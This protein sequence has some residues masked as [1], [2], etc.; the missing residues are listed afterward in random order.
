MLWASLLPQGDEWPGAL[1]DTDRAGT[2]GPCDLTAEEAIVTPFSQTSAGLFCI[3][4]L[5]SKH[6]L[7]RVGVGGLGYGAA[8]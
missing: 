2:D 8:F 7:S 5:V 6:S 1:P 3:V 4:A